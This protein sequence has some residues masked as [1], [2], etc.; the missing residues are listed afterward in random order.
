MTPIEIS[1]N[2]SPVSPIFVDPRTWVPTIRCAPRNALLCTLLGPLTPGTWHRSGNLVETKCP[3]KRNKPV[4]SRER[5]DG[6]VSQPNDGSK[7]QYLFFW[8][9]FLASFILRQ[10]GSKIPKNWSILGKF[11]NPPLGTTAAV[12]AIIC[13]NILGCPRSQ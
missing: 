3:T 9:S 6:M 7:K 2:N 10:F 12:L 8:H 5:D 1:T 4:S 13:P 11:P